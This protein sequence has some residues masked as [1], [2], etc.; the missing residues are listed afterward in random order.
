[1]SPSIDKAFLLAAGY[2]MR[3]R[4]L[5]ETCPKP[6][7]KVAGKPIIDY[8][9]DALKQAGVRDVIVNLNYLGHML[10]DHLK[11]REDM[12]IT[13][14]WEDELLDTGGGVKKEHDFFGDDPFFVLN[15]D[16]IWKST[17]RPA[18]ELLKDNW[19]DE[20]MDL[21]LL[22]Q[23]LSD[24]PIDFIAAGDYFLD[25]DTGRLRRRRDADAAPYMFMGPRIVHPRVFKDAPKGAF[26]FRE[27]FDTAES[28]DRLYGAVHTGKWY[29]VG[30]PEA[31]RETDEILRGEQAA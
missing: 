23:S 16:V 25:D 4:P 1:M 30:T 8:A 20:D 5:T 19:H 17:D 22:L 21:L 12:N 7:L 9:L 11:A 24:M 13:L 27:L 15:G 26:S 2:G 29:H 6:L 10:E 18:L 31:L 14:S 28:K 3:M